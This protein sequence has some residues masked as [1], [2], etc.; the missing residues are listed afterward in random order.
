MVWWDQASRSLLQEPRASLEVSRSVDLQTLREGRHRHG[1]KRRCL[2]DDGTE[3]QRSH[4]EEVSKANTKVIEQSNLRDVQF[5]NRDAF[6]RNRALSSKP[7]YTMAPGLDKMKERRRLIEL[8][9]AVLGCSDKDDFQCCVC[10]ADLTFIALYWGQQPKIT[11]NASVDRIISGENPGYTGP[12]SHCACTGCQH[13]KGE[14][15]LKFSA[16]LILVLRRAS[17]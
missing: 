1:P 6:V 14:Y 4:F 8:F 9:R 7:Y 3:E 17:F 12:N 5:V 2:L 10:L 16:A 15:S 11:T 13:V